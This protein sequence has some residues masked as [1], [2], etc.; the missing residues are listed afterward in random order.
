MHKELA[1]ACQQESCTLYRSICVDSGSLE[2]IAE[3]ILSL[4]AT[5]LLY[6]KAQEDDKALSTYLE[7]QRLAK[8]IHMH[9]PDFEDGK[10]RILSISRVLGDFA[11][12]NKRYDTALASYQEYKRHAA[13]L[14]ENNPSRKQWQSSL[15]NALKATGK[16]YLRLENYQSAQQEF[17]EAINHVNELVKKANT[18]PFFSLM[19]EIYLYFSH[20][21]FHLKDYERCYYAALSAKQVLT[22]LRENGAHPAPENIKWADNILAVFEKQE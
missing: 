17:G 21:C 15:V 6:E 7:A 20:T 1:I 14:Y 18:V 10:M 3:Y 22:M 4:Q 11:F 13:E 8:E 16:S 2:D 19:A 5:G 12:K 9:N